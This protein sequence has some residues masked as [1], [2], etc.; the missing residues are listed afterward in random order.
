MTLYIRDK[1]YGFH[2]QKGA[3]VSFRMRCPKCQFDHELQTTECLKCGIVFS[4]YQPP[5][6]LEEPAQPAAEPPEPFEVESE[7]LISRSDAIMEFKYRIFA[8]PLA[9]LVARLVAASG[10][11]L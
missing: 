1:F 5:P 4:R 9:L 8:L 11:R 10:L 7:P 6:A 3:A 2:R